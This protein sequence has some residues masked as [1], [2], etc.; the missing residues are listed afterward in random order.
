MGIINI[1]TTMKETDDNK[2]IGLCI[3]VFVSGTFVKNA[4]MEA[5]NS[6]A[7]ESV[8]VPRISI[9]RIFLDIINPAIHMIRVR[10]RMSTPSMM[11]EF[12]N[13]ESRTICMSS[14]PSNIV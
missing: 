9:N 7:F 8:I 13:D 12:A 3:I 14:T 5:S 1:M 2:T 10:A 4:A 11:N 6:G